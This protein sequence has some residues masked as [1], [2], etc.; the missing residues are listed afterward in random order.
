MRRLFSYLAFIIA[1]SAHVLCG[2]NSL[3]SSGFVILREIIPEIELEMRYCYS[4]NFVGEPIDG[5]TDPIAIVTKE[6]AYALR[7]VVAELKLKG[8]TLK[9]YDAYR[10]QRAVDHF[11]RWAQN[12]ADTRMKQDFYPEVH[13]SNLF[14]YGYIAS[15]SGHTKGSTVDLTLYDIN[16]HCDVDM[17]G[18]FD[19]FGYKSHPDYPYL[20]TAQKTNREL[21]RTVM[22][23]HGFRG[24]DT[25]WW[26]FTLINEPY[27]STYFNFPVS[28]VA[29]GR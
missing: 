29:M 10:P 8:Y 19:Y 13:K 5:Y 12:I 23:K 17:G 20:T 15:R 9:I 27:P 4:Y 11:V 2:A 22:L 18:G 26:H 25:E 6:T 3:D 7:N 16:K 28:Y 1:L 14:S 21:L 24:I